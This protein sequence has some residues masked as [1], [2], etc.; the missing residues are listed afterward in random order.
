MTTTWYLI[1]PNGVTCRIVHSDCREGLKSYAQ[2]IDLII[3][4][5]PYADARKTHYDSVM[6]DD[7]SQWFTQFHEVFWPA[8]KPQ[9]SF[10][11]NIKDKV[12][13]GVRHRYVWQTIQHLSA[14]GWQCIDDYLW[15]K[16]TSVPGYWP[17][18]LRDAWE[19]IFHLSK[20]KKPFV[21][22]DAV[23]IPASFA[24]VDRVKHLNPSQVV[25][26]SSATGSGFKR[27]LSAWKNKEWV[28]PTNVLHLS[29]ETC[30][31]GHPA[32]FP[33]ALPVFFILLLSKPNDVILDPFA[34]SGTTAVAAIQLGRNCVLMD[35]KYEYCLLAKQRLIRECNM[36]EVL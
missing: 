7:Y 9:G 36:R 30:N 32:V 11:I 18:R 22:Q 25:S 21:D 4:S 5:P 26:I 1:D 10:V 14:L 2:K 3:T 8:L 15:N 17:T 13:D 12:V 29:T 31:K 16:K 28:L 27:N 33:V 24:T 35:N 23:K 19:Y 6:P 20:S 34:G